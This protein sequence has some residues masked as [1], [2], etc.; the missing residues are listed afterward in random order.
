MSTALAIIEEKEINSN[1]TIFYN[2]PF[3]KITSYGPAGIFKL[4]E[5]KNRYKIFFITSKS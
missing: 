1:I 5:E 2:L 3:N 4:E